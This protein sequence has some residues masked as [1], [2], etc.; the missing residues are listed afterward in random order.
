MKLM[1]AP[2]LGPL[3]EP[4]PYFYINDYSHVFSQSTE[5]FITEQGEKLY[6]ATGAQVV[7]VSV[8]NT[9][10]ATLEEY[11]NKLFNEWGIGSEKRDNGVLILFTTDEAHVRMEIGY[12]LEGCLPDARCGRILDQYAVE[13]MHAGNWNAAA[14]N[15]WAEAA[16]AAYV[17][18]RFGRRIRSLARRRSPYG[19]SS[20][21][22]QSRPILTADTNPPRC[23]RCRAAT[24]L[25]PCI[26]AYCVRGIISPT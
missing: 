2:A 5:T 12:G 7:V 26:S 22:S 19:S 25:R 6:A 24:G 15:T 20:R 21:I 18:Y 8:P 14:V 9:G 1:P 4:T 23:A 16:R 17:D 13:D 11:S 10:N 3:P